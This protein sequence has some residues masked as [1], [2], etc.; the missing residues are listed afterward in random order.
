MS[1]AD[2]VAIVL[3]VVLAGV[4]GAVVVALG[5]FTRTLRDLRR[6]VDELRAETLPAVD[7]LREAVTTTVYNVE[8][9]DRL[10]TAA[11]SVEDRVDNASRLAYRTIQSPV[12]KALALGAGVQRTAQRLAGKDPAPLAAAPAP[13][14][15][16]RL[17]R[18]AG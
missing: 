5:A 4:A 2:V 6:A 15:K 3:A 13:S 12:V 8:R 1:A 9:V 10:V 7:E 11:Q 16:R 14:R 18:K 17:R